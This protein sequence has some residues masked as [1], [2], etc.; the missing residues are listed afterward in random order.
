MQVKRNLLLLSLFLGL[1]CASLHAQ[2]NDYT[3]R[4]NLAQQALKAQRY[5]EALL[6]IMQAEY[7]TGSNRVACQHF[8]REILELKAKYWLQNN[9]PLLP[10]E[11]YL[12]PPADQKAKRDIELFAEKLIERWYNMN[13]HAYGA[14]PLALAKYI[15]EITNNQNVPALELRSNWLASNSKFGYIGY[16]NPMKLHNSNQFRAQ[17]QPGP[18]PIVFYAVKDEVK[19]FDFQYSRRE[20]P[21][22]VPKDLRAGKQIQHLSFSSWGNLLVCENT[23]TVKIYN[24]EHP[25]DSA[26]FVHTKEKVNWGSFLSENIFITTNE[27]HPGKIDFYRLNAANTWTFQRSITPSSNASDLLRLVVG[28]ELFLAW[29]GG[30]AQLFN[31]DGIQTAQMSLSSPILNGTVSKDGSK[32]ALQIKSGSVYLFDNNG[33]FQ[34]SL[35]TFSSTTILSGLAFSPDRRYLAAG[36]IEEV[37]A[38][39]ISHALQNPY[40]FVT[41]RGSSDDKTGNIVF[42]SNGKKIFWLNEHGTYHWAN[43][44]NPDFNFSKE[45][46]TLPFKSLIASGFMDESDCFCTNDVSI[47]SECAKW[48]KSKIHSNNRHSINGKFYLLHANLFSE[49]AIQVSPTRKNSALAAE[50]RQGIANIDNYFSGRYFPGPPPPVRDNLI[51]DSIYVAREPDNYSELI[52]SLTTAKQKGELNATTRQSIAI[53]FFY[54]AWRRIYKKDYQG[55]IV[56]AQK[57]QQIDPTIAWG[58]SHLA[59]AYLLNGEWPK[60]KKIYSQ[61]QHV[62]WENSGSGNLIKYA[63]L[64]E[65]FAEDLRILEMHNFKHPDFAKLRQLLGLGKND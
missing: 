14:E 47:L 7:S 27:S 30:T 55:A 15:C 40:P 54:L 13:V 21:N 18:Y 31:A 26:I 9:G 25:D 37:Y 52:E 57:G 39:D 65:Y 28:S 3:Y 29:I 11:H 5:D 17:F 44:E 34:D 10:L 42:S 50:I 63:F 16:H 4:L 45:I 2:L 48:F 41:W 19:A 46:Q 33:K 12:K 62:R 43:F 51:L 1:C 8:A 49:R 23:D 20:N 61:W 56:A 38:W 6:T 22:D 60:A 32:I 59:L 36:T 53:S 35:K 64:S 24:T 58:V